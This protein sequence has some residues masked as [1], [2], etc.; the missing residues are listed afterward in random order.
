MTYA[1]LERGWAKSRLILDL[2]TR[3]HKQTDLAAKYGC[4]QSAISQFANKHFDEIEGRRAYLDDEWAD[5]WI[6]DKKNRVAEYQDDVEAINEALD[7][8]KDPQ[9]LRAKLAI[10]RQ[11]AEELG[12]LKSQVEL[13]GALT[14]VV[15]GVNLDALK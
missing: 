1:K 9:L 5:L 15:E 2:A 14:Y 6:A 4:T 12:Q 7:T 3:E 11:V 13:S 10:M 8:E